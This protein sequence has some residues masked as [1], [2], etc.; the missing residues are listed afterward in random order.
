MYKR[1]I[2]FFVASESIN[3]TSKLNGDQVFIL[4]AKFTVASKTEVMQQ[5]VSHLVKVS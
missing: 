4:D 1:I 3:F 2:Y 5:L